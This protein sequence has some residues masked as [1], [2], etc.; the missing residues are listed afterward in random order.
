MKSKVIIVI[1]LLAGVLATFTAYRYMESEKESIKKPKIPTT[2]VIVATK[3]LSIGTVLKAEHLKLNDWPE[4]ILPAGNFKMIDELVDRVI[5]TEVHVNEPILDYKLAP[6]G[7]ASGFS[8]IIP[9]G[10]RAVTV[11]VNVVIGVSGFILPNT[12]VD[13]I[14]TV[15]PSQKKEDTISKTILENVKVL[16]VDQTFEP[17]DDDPMTVQSV[18]L[19]VAP[20]EAEKLT[21]ASNAGK[22]QLTL[23]NAA[24]EMPAMTAGMRL[25]ELLATNQPVTRRT[26]R[27]VRQSTPPPAKV[28]T[29]ASKPIPTSK[30]V[31]VIRSSKRTTV[32][33]E[34]ENEKNK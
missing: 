28:E 27:V 9:P 5:K 14:A 2:G 3:D 11:A 20:E 15:S 34:D 26:P 23:R 16:A 24:D 12:K 25:G 18:T 30:E 13:V 32:T 4:D 21:L 19:L 7:S 29:P 33:F 1:A 17:K 31:E 6:M 10:M 22:L 8:S